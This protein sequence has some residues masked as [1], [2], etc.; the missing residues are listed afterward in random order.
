MH[1]KRPCARRETPSRARRPSRRRC[2]YRAVWV[3]RPR[4][5]SADEASALVHYA[6]QGGALVYL[7]DRAHGDAPREDGQRIVQALL[8]GRG[9]SIEHPLDAHETD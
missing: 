7:T 4:S 3:V 1:S 2:S 5:I 6:N 8:P 9:V